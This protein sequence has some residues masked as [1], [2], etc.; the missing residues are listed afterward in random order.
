MSTLLSSSRSDYW[1]SRTSSTITVSTFKLNPVCGK[2][3]MIVHNLHTR[4]YPRPRLPLSQSGTDVP[5]ELLSP[6]KTY[7]SDT[8]WLQGVST[9]DQLPLVLLIPPPNLPNLSTFCLS[10]PFPTFTGLQPSVL[11]PRN[12]CWNTGNLWKWVVV[13]FNT[14]FR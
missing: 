14:N 7:V 6:S 9:P 3:T 10:V 11:I 2:Q 12:G 8:L 4:P 13:H 5:R 1:T